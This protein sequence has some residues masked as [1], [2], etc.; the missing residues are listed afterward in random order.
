MHV[1][2]RVDKMAAHAKKGAAASPL[3]VEFVPL[4][5]SCHA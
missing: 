3:F 1:I 2:G 4:H 5:E